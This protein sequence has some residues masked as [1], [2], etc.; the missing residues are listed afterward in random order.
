MTQTQEDPPSLTTLAEDVAD[1]LPEHIVTVSTLRTATANGSVRKCTVTISKYGYEHHYVNVQAPTIL[2]AWQEAL[3]CLAKASLTREEH[4][5]L[6]AVFL[7]H[8]S[9]QVVNPTTVRLLS[10]E[11][12]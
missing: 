11:S 2:Q 7:G 9:H 3:Q 1:A 6:E 5:R 4:V 12:R 10:L 8:C